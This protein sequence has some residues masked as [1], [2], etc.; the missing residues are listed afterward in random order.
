M[1]AVR[2]GDAARYQ[3]GPIRRA[4]AVVDG[5]ASRSAEAAAFLYKT[6]E[7]KACAL[8]IC[9]GGENTDYRWLPERI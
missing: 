2:S 3:S 9:S 8:N 7:L 6:E 5:G 1:S 4:E